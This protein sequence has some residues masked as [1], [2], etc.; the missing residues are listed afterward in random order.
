MSESETKFCKH[1]GTKIPKSAVVC[2]ACGCQVEEMAHSASPAPVAAPSI[3]VQNVNQTN[4]NTAGGA[5]AEVGS[6]RMCNKWTTFLL[7]LFLGALGAHK[8]YEG[9][10]VMGILYLFT[11][12]FCGV[13]L[14]IDFFV[15]LGKPT[16]YPAI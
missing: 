12:G 6:G 3:V 14:F 15:I 10:V 9:K 16:N 8:F 1:C 2:T 4:T 5:G 7:W 11:A 13:G